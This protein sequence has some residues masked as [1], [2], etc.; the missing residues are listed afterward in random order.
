MPRLVAIDSGPVVRLF[1]RDDEHHEE[2]VQFF[3]GFKGQ[4]FLTVPVVTEVMH[5]LDFRV[6]VQLDFLLWIRRGA[7]AVEDLT[8][9]DFDRVIELV[10]KYA[11]RP[12]DFADASLVVACERLN[13]K[14]I[15]SIDSDIEIYRFKDRQP[16]KNVFPK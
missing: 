16:F 12:M 1:D 7:L 13:T 14:L 15:A 5:L 3:S 9:A 4:G 8:D 6:S 10:G 11:D 2:A